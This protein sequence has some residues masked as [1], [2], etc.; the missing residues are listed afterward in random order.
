MYTLGTRVLIIRSSAYTPQMISTSSV[1]HYS[2]LWA[3][4]RATMPAVRCSSPQAEQSMPQHQHIWPDTN[5]GHNTVMEAEAAIIA[6]AKG[7]ILLDTLFDEALLGP[8][9]LRTQ[10]HRVWLPVLN[11]ISNAGNIE[12]SEKA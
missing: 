12:A 1:S 4:H 2:S 6:Q 3:I 9:E 11:H 8:V 7:L 10:V 5:S